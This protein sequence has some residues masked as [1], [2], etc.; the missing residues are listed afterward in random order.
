MNTITAPLTTAELIAAADSDNFVT[1]NIEV[2]IDTL[3]DNDFEGFLDFLSSSV[4]GTELL[5]DIAYKPISVNGE[6]IVLSVSGD[7]SEI[8]DSEED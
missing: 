4:T 2:G 3:V 1:V 7:I 8:V 5:M 6:S